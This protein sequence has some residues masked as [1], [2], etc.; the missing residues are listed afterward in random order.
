MG[1][2]PERADYW[3]EFVG[4]RCGYPAPRRLKAQ[5]AAAEFFDFCQCGCNSFSVRLPQGTSIPA[6]ATAYKMQ[7]AI[8]EADF[9]L[10]HDKHLEII[11]FADGAGNLSYIEVDCCANSFPVPDD[12]DSLEAPYATN[13]SKRVLP[14]L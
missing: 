14:D 7:T 11:L 6:L 5:L 9:V 12:L 1:N 4:N 13:P 3:R 2:G 8:F 10:P